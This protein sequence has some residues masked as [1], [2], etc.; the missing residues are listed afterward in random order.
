M[1]RGGIV[2]ALVTAIAWPPA[3]ARAENAVL[4]GADVVEGDEAPGL[5]AFTFDDGP[6]V[7]TTD[8][9]IDALLA[10]D[11][12]ATFFVVGKRLRGKRA[13]PAR[14]LLARM[15][16]H[17]FDV[18]N[19]SF[20]HPNLAQLDAKKNAAQIDRT[21]ELI[22]ELTGG[23]V[24]LFRAPFGALGKAT[25]AHA[26]SHKLTIVE[27]S[28]DSLDWRRPK[29]DRMR[30]AVIEG[31]VREN[32]GVVLMHDT[33]KLTARTIAGILDDLEALNCERLAGG[34]APIVPVSIHYFLRDGDRPRVVPP[35]VEARTQRYRE[36]LPD[37]CA[38][39]AGKMANR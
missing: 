3:S 28:I 29:A 30:K 24:G 9:V 35:E 8:V 20:S 38:A 37:R 39:R 1:S 12:P 15:I 7:G 21:N 17:G 16:E 11:V 19:H 27:W 23:P 6:K 34:E 31:I 36:S 13:Q 5:V 26:A 32:G 14:D 25:R 18:G 33:K 4:G 22:A 10:Y 2:L